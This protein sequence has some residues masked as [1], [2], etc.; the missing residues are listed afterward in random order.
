MNKKGFTLVELLAVIVILGL[1]TTIAAY[2]IF[3]VWGKSKEGLLKDRIQSIE[4][5]AIT[6]Y[7]ENRQ[8]LTE[9][10]SINGKNYNTCKVVTVQDLLNLGI[11]ETQEENQKITNDVT[12]C[13]M[14]N[15]IVTVYRKNNRVQAKMTDIK[16]NNTTC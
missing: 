15:D 13:N 4:N 9:S 16:S 1:V 8:L 5:A 2:S 3:N 12:G 10:C 7:S 6:Y 11:L 14:V